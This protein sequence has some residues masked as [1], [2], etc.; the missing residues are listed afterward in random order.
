MSPQ[1]PDILGPQA[2]ATVGTAGVFRPRVSWAVLEDRLLV[3][4][5]GDDRVSF[6]HG[7]CSNDIKGMAVH[8]VAPALLLDDRAR[9][10]ADLFVW[11]EADAFIL[12]I[13]RA[14][15]PTARSHLEKFLVA[16]DVEFEEKPE[17]GVLFLQGE[18]AANCVEQIAAGSGALDPWHTTGAGE[19]LIANLPR[20]GPSAYS[21][22]APAECLGRLKTTVAAR[23]DAVAFD[24][25]AIDAI[26]IAHGVARVGIDTDAKT[27]ALEAHFERAISFSKG[28]YIGQETIER[29]TA[30]GSLKKRL[31]GL[32][33]DGGRIPAVNAAI[34]LDDHVVGRLTSVA[35]SA[36]DQII[37]LA[38][39]HHEAWTGGTKVAIDDPDASISAT[40]ADL[41]LR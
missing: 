3:R 25:N 1:A 11:A 35:R 2:A 31:R 24:S 22:I 23:E 4:M 40:V 17:L 39:L 10:I 41:P 34:R 16:D 21:I 19:T 12:E 33:I 5:I 13:D 18:S 7:M 30:H 36:E 29:A 27:L 9:L 32:R 8:T 26:R 20:F 28:C 37:G 14:L 38:I 15:W 6:L